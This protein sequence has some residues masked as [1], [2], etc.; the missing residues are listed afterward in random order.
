MSQDDDEFKRAVSVTGGIIGN[1][2]YPLEISPAAAIDVEAAIK[3]VAEDLQEVIETTDGLPGNCFPASCFVSYALFKHKI[4][5][6]MTIGDVELVDGMY[7]NLTREGLAAQISAGYE[8]EIIDGKLY[9]KRLS[10]HAWITLENG[11]VID[12][13]I[14]AS[15][16]RKKAEQGPPLSF[17]NAIYFSGKA[18]TQVVRHRPFLVGGLYHERVLL[19]PN[20]SMYNFYVNWFDYYDRHMAG[21]DELRRR[22]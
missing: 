14:L 9:G 15:Q 19:H 1:G 18:G 11:V 7:C 21:L 8:T 13:T 22:V 12:A 10:S 2:S 3:T 17:E 6:V 4:K 20:D 16:Y 5:H